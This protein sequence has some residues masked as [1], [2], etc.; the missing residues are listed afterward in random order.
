MTLAEPVA[1]ARTALS[2]AGTG[3]IDD[4]SLLHA[5]QM[6]IAMSRNKNKIPHP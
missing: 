1:P 4:G 5:L 3:N 2:L 6:A